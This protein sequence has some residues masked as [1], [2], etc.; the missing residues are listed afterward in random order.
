VKTK[1][2]GAVLTVTAAFRKLAG[3]TD[4]GLAN[5]FRPAAAAALRELRERGVDYT[6]NVYGVLKGEAGPPVTA[7]LLTSRGE[8][9]VGLCE[10]VGRLPEKVRALVL[11][12]FEAA[13]G[14]TQN[15]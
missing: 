12:A 8:C 7:F 13:A 3:M 2:E 15:N 14:D 10:D 9:V 6:V 11:D 4:A 1:G 5:N